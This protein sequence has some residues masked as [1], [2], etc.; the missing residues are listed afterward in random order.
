MI[1]IES[2]VAQ[3]QS[4]RQVSFRSGDRVCLNGDLK[5]TGTLI[6]PL[7]KTNP[8]RWTVEFDDGY[9]EAVIV[10]QFSLIT[11]VHE[12]NSEDESI[13]SKTLDKEKYETEIEQLK[14]ELIVL[15]RKNE[16]LKEELK[17]AQQIIR[18]AKDISPVVRPSLKRVLRLAHKACMDVKRTASGWILQMGHLARK[19]RRLGDIWLLLSQ[20]NWCLSEIFRPDTL[21]PVDQIKPPSF[22]SSVTSHQSSVISNHHLK[23]KK[24]N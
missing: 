24:V 17:K 18:Q 20:D 16:E 5:Y 12:E 13:K 8:A 4:K 6:R 22:Q 14:Q 11:P 19:F 10:D 1:N 15:K 7:E 21:N 3:I 9:Y 23:R 2:S